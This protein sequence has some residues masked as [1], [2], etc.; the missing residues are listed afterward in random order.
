MV[1]KSL[2]ISFFFHIMVEESV[3]EKEMN[4]LKICIIEDEKSIRDDIEF[5][6]RNAG[7]ET[8]CAE[9]FMTVPDL[10]RQCEPDLILLDINLQGNDGFSICK[11]IR[12]N[13][14]VPIIFLTG[15]MTAMDELKALTLG[16]D[17]YITKPYHPTL[18]LA[19]IAT[20][21]KRSAS[22]HQEEEHV[23]IYKEL[24]FDLRS[25]KIAYQDKHEELTKNEFR[26]L[27]YLF[28]RKGEVIP[29]LDIVEYL[30]DNDVFID[31]SALSVT[32]TRLRQKIE[33]LGIKDFIKTKRGV[34]YQI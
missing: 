33:N 23:L 18:L 7:Y 25:Y 24:T 29:R 27:Y 30:W 6:L 15:N 4:H 26:L 5:L 19:R 11:E 17:D 8:I 34:G 16:G 1:L 20:V 28:E 32:M 12:D 31:D 3:Y 13:S 22:N 21:L 10:V 14:E 2:I 9:D